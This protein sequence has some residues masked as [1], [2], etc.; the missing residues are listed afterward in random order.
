MKPSVGEMS[1]VIKGE[2]K[3]NIYIG[4]GSNQSYEMFVIIDFALWSF[5]VNVCSCMCFFVCIHVL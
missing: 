1:A 2:I 3:D 5:L 4:I